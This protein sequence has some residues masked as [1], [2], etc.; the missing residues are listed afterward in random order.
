MKES[1]F[2][3]NNLISYYLNMVV[4]TR[5]HSHTILKQ[6]DKRVSKSGN[7]THLGENG[8]Q[9]KKIWARKLDDA[10]WTYRTTF[11]THLTISL[12]RLVYEKICHLL[13]EIKHKAY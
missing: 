1:I 12:Y 10:F 3:I 11:K 13:V 2:I 4:G 6:I 7:Q 9:I 8:E 5:H